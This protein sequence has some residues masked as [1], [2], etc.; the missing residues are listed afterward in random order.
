MRLLSLILSRNPLAWS[1]GKELLPEQLQTVAIGLHS[2]DITAIKGDYGTG[3]DDRG[4]Y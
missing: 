3:G 4:E 1:K 2:I